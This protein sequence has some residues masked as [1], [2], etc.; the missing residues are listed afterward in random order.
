MRRPIP[1]PLTTSIF[2][3]FLVLSTAGCASGP[4]E[5]RTPRDKL[6]RVGLEIVSSADALLTPNEA[7]RFIA[8]RVIPGA[9]NPALPLHP[10]GYLIVG[11]DRALVS[12]IA[13][14][15]QAIADWRPGERIHLIVRRNPHTGDEAEWWESDVEWLLP[16]R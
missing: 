5:L 6:A 13:S 2:A 11:C 10:A 4:A 14:L 12:D 1:N 16:E 15:W 9:K 7:S 8:C 3:T